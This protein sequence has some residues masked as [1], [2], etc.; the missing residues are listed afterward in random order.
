MVISY[1]RIS[2]FSCLWI[3][4]STISTSNFITISICSITSNSCCKWSNST[5]WSNINRITSC[6]W[7][8]IYRFTRIWTTSIPPSC[9]IRTVSWITSFISWISYSIS[10]PRDTIILTFYM[11]DIIWRIWVIIRFIIIYFI[12]NH[13]IVTPFSSISSSSWMLFN[14]PICRTSFNNSHRTIWRN[15]KIIVF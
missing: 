12:I 10:T 1:C 2:T 8:Y 3:N 9:L 15:F 7:I 5:I 11:R 6:R 14:S 4:S 13:K